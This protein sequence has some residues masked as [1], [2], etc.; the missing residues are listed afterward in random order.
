M[1]R[2]NYT[3]DILYQYALNIQS[4]ARSIKITPIVIGHV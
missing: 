3:F 2:A 1:V 4:S